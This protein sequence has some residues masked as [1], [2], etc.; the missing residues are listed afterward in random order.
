VAINLNDALVLI[1]SFSTKA[2]TVFAANKNDEEKSYS[3]VLATKGNRLSSE[4]TQYIDTICPT[5]GLSLEA[6]GH[7]VEL[8]AASNLS[9]QPDMYA[10]LTGELG[11]WDNDWLLLAHEGGDPIIVK[12]SETTEGSAEQNTVYSAMQG[13]GF[14]DF[15]PIADSIGQFLVCICAIEHALNFP[16]LGQPLDDDFNLAPAAA[17][18]L[19]PFLRQHAG[20]HYDEWAAVFENYQMG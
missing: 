15:A 4:L 20:A 13:M 7:P 12:T 18:W 11:K 19:F 2:N 9:W 16:G 14:W 3:P 10:Q 6:V 8:I 1:A 17:N 5:A